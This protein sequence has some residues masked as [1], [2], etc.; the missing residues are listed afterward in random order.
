MFRGNEAVPQFPRKNNFRPFLRAVSFQFDGSLHWELP[1]SELDDMISGLSAMSFELYEVKVT[2]E[3]IDVWN[4]GGKV[5]GTTEITVHSSGFRMG[6]Y[7]PGRRV[8]RPDMPLVMW[9]RRICNREAY[10]N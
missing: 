1:R 5:S 8:F 10:S 9:V 6:F 7:G 4:G 3:H 2:A